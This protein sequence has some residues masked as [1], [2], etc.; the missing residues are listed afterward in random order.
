MSSLKVQRVLAA[1]A[2]G[3]AAAF[4]AGATRA[5]IIS[6]GDVYPDPSAPGY[7]SPTIDCTLSYGPLLI[8]RRFDPSVANGSVTVNGGSVLS[9]PMGFFAGANNGNGSNG[10]LTITGAG[11]QFLIPFGP[12]NFN[13]GFG[14]GDVGS[15]VVENGG[16]LTTLGGTTAPSDI[17]T[18][19][20]STGTLTI[21]SGGRFD[22]A[23]P[24]IVLGGGMAGGISGAITSG[25]LIVE[26]GGIANVTGFIGMGNFSGSNASIRVSDAGSVLRIDP[27]GGD[28][29]LTIGSD[30]IGNAVVLVEKGGLLQTVNGP[31]RLGAL[32]GY[33]HVVTVRDAG[34]RIDLGVGP[35]NA[36]GNG[37]LTTVSVLDGGTLKVGSAY[38]SQ[39]TL[40]VSGTGSTLDLA[41]GA[42]L[43]LGVGGKLGVQSGAQAFVGSPTPGTPIPE[44]P[45]STSL[46]A[47]GLGSTGTLRVQGGTVEGSFTIVGSAGTVNVTNGGQVTMSQA[48]HLGINAPGT[49]VLSISQGGQLTA[50][51]IL[52]G[53][54][55]GSAAATV[56]GP[57]SRLDALGTRPAIWPGLHV[58]S[59]PGS[60]GSLTLQ[61]GA[62]SAALGVGVGF[63]GGSTGQLSVRGAGSR[64]ESLGGINVG[65][66]GQGTMLLSDE[67]AAKARS[68][69]IG[70]SLGATGTLTVTGPGSTLT[71]ATTSDIPASMTVGRQGVGALYVAGGGRVLIDAIPMNPTRFGGLVAG[72]GFNTTAT[73]TG[74]ISVSGPGS[75]IRLVQNAGAPTQYYATTVGWQGTG[76][77]HVTNG[78]RMINDNSDAAFSVVGRAPTG[79]G[80]VL[81]DGPGSRWE[82]GKRLF[83][84]TD[85]NAESDS[86]EF[87][88]PL[89]NGGT[90]AVTIS[91]GGVVKV[92]DYAYIAAGGTLN[93]NG[94]VDGDVIVAGGTVMPG[95]SP[96][97]LAITGDFTMGS[98][99]L[100]IEVAGLGPGQFDILDIGGDARLNGGIIRFAFIDGFLPG[101]G[102]TFDFLLASSLSLGSVGYQYSG[103]APGFEFDVEWTGNAFQLVALND[104]AAAPEPST[105]ALLGLGLAGLAATCRRKR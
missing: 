33:Q 53:S 30:G 9:S 100:E 41:P 76:V 94:T 44:F 89:G 36:S 23:G 62:Q 74:S 24:W 31:L 54:G 22:F 66:S 7:C 52:I 26:Q 93:G 77:L 86:P 59:N 32:A 25:S 83:V 78:G 47:V 17:G 29:A 46:L 71:L 40:L 101:A 79:T 63:E 28:Q 105:L 96:G 97:T 20:G 6:V 34:S 81:V 19:E 92:T 45:G 42:T 5:A 65:V 56:S 2:F 15:V 87:M 60:V 21:R 16:R 98:G 61:G 55:G 103:A 14:P 12:G 80:T 51:S 37:G 38:V 90:G 68:A 10:T 1:I 85:V 69:V 13:I 64:L 49:A 8:G 43:T 3:L 104:A 73:G 99:I 27:A 57:G 11:S 18:Q 58:G 4:S 95:T 82:A 35:L 75:E 70:S 39:G 50:P 102:N 84:A 67:G 48:F 91:N 88:T 72:G